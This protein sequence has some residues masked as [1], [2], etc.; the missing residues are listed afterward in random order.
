MWPG[1]AQRRRKCC[2]P[3]ADVGGGEPSPGAD[4]GGGE[5]SPAGGRCGRRASS[6]R[7]SA[8]SRGVVA[9]EVWLLSLAVPLTSLLSCR[10]VGPAGLPRSMD[11]AHGRH[12]TRCGMGVVPFT[13]CHPTRYGVQ[14]GTARDPTRYDIRTS[15]LC[16]GFP[17]GVPLLHDTAS[18]HSRLP[19]SHFSMSLSASWSCLTAALFASSVIASCRRVLASTV[20]QR[21]GTR[22]NMVPHPSRRHCKTQ[23]APRTIAGRPEHKVIAGRPEHKVYSSTRV[24][25]G[26]NPFDSQT[27]WP[28][29]DRRCGRRRALLVGL[30]QADLRARRISLTSSAIDSAWRLSPVSCEPAWV[31]RAQSRCRSGSGGEGG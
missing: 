19:T 16:I 30:A 31:S 23:R 26:L 29:A 27:V 20:L 2:S 10:R 14:H 4:V 22:C 6:G 8:A 9:S 25:C 18:S 7:T 21:S 13:I 5:P 17:H 15:M 12:P 11:C 1:R 3:G 24:R 28:S